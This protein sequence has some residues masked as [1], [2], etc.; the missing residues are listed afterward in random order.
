M[1]S[2]KVKEFTFGQK[3]VTFVTA[4]DFDADNFS[5]FL[6]GLPAPVIDKVLDVFINLIDAMSAAYINRLVQDNELD[7]YVKAQR[8]HDSLAPFR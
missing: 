3:F 6:I 4:Y 8:I 1:A 2:S 7:V 5:T